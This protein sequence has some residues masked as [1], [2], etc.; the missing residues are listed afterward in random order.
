MAKSDAVLTKSDAV[1][2]C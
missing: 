1:F 2:R